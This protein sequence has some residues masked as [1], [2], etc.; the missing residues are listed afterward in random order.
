MSKYFKKY[1]GN[2]TS[3]FLL[4]SVYLAAGLTF[5]ALLFLLVYIFLLWL[6]GFDKTE[7]NIIKEVL[8]N[9][10]YTII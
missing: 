2:K 6:I 8:Y 3:F 1:A 5:L 10:M 4:G 9:R 7:K